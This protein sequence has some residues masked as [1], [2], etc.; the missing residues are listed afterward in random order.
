MIRL[1]GVQCFALKKLLLLQIQSLLRDLAYCGVTTET[2]ADPNLTK[3]D[4]FPVTL[5]RLGLILSVAC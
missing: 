4:G 5:D 1:T 3:T 2:W